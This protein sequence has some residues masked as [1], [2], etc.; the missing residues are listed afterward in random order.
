MFTGVADLLPQRGDTPFEGERA[1]RHPPTVAGLPDNEVGVGAGVGEEDFV[2]LRVSGQLDDRADLD[3][4]LIQR[5]QQIRQTG[6]ALGALLAARHHE[7]PLRP[8][9]QRGPD[10]LAIDDP[11][12][13]LFV[14]YRGGCDVG[15][16]TARA[17]L[18]IA[19]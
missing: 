2:E 8:V 12:L 17:G 7:T 16:V 4:R 1:H 11:V 19:L 10:L 18:G 13:T 3:A 14:E 6:V 15:E 5:D 9:R